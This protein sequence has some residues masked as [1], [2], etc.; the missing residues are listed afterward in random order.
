MSG[1]Y[2]STKLEKIE[3]DDEDEAVLRDKIKRQVFEK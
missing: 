3:R 2:N 1:F